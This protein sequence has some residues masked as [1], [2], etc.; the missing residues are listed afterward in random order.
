LVGCRVTAS[1]RFVF[2]FGVTNDKPRP[3]SLTNITTITRIVSPE[4]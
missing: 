1:A 3:L 2:R 4:I